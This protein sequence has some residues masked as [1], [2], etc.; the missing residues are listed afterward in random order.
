[1]TG[2][3]SSLAS[4]VTGSLS[5]RVRAEET[6]K[7]LPLD[8][9]AELG[10]AQ[11]LVQRIKSVGGNVPG[12]LV[13]KFVQASD[14]EWDAIEFLG[15]PTSSGWQVFVRRFTP[16]VREWCRQSGLGAHEG[17]DVLQDVC[18]R[19]HRSTLPAS[20]SQ[21]EFD[22]G[23]VLPWLKT[24]TLNV[25]RSHVKSSSRMPVC[26]G[27]NAD[28][29][30][31][32]SMS[33]QRVD[34]RE[35]LQAVL[36]RTKRRVGHKWISFQMRCLEWVAYDEIVSAT[37]LRYETAQNYVSLVRKVFV[38]EWRRADCQQDK[39]TNPNKSSGLP[40]DQ[41]AGLRR[42]KSTEIG[43]ELPFSH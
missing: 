30:G 8:V 24:V 1:M 22:K 25:I 28:D 39:E 13:F 5:D 14:A 19:I 20:R 6:K 2:Q 3:Q 40:S 7:A 16:L 26:I 31:D 15:Q 17:E 29:T 43:Q 12:G 10:H 33:T 42:V 9:T 23:G 18:L 4:A 37:G 11:I 38:E 35:H 34:E 32:E 41:A 21:F 36:A 27:V